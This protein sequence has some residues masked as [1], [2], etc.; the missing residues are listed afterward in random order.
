MELNWKVNTL[1]GT[2]A[3]LL[4]YFFSITNNIW[5]TSILRAIFGFLFFFLIGYILRFL[6]SQ[7]N[8]KKIENNSNLIHEQFTEDVLEQAQEELLG[9]L[10]KEDILFQQIPLHSLHKG[11]DRSS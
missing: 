7:M 9:E 5:Q 1:L 6:L 11:E 8:V 3:F 4:T 2:T 10:D